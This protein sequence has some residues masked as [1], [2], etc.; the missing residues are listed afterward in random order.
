MKLV[1]RSLIDCEIIV[2]DAGVF[3]DYPCAGALVIGVFL[4]NMQEGG[5][6][7]VFRFIEGELTIFLG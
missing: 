1:L 2:P 5:Q 6:A 7:F 4:R 3:G